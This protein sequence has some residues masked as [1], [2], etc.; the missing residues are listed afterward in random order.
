MAAA[1][2]RSHEPAAAALC[3]PSKGPSLRPAPMLGP[4]ALPA[5]RRQVCRRWKALLDSPSG[6]QALWGSLVVDFG[7][8]LVTSV[9]T[10][11]R[12]S[13][14]QPTDDEFREVTSW[15]GGSRRQAVP[16]GP[17]GG[18]PEAPAPPAARGAGTL[19]PQAPPHCP[20]SAPAAAARRPLLPCGWTSTDWW[21]L[22]G[23]AAPR[24]TA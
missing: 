6:R 8:E 23:S 10:P 1:H 18:A 20:R 22:C 2:V 24:C 5:R 17:G 4:R 21:T 15:A 9:H 13:E 7:H 16:G 11:I 19:G 14:A 3:K 12:W